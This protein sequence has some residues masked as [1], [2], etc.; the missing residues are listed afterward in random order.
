[1]IARV[2]ALCGAQYEWGVHVAAFSAPADSARSAGG[3]RQPAGRAGGAA[4]ARPT[5][6][7]PVRRTACDR[8]RQRCAVERTRPRV[9]H[10]A[11]D[12]T[13]HA[14][15]L[16]PGDQLRVQCR[17]RALEPGRPAG[18]ATGQRVESSSTSNFSVALGGITPPA[19][20]AP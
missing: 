6:G 2:C 17:R 12:R 7:A 20:R 3:D 16:V 14:G 13:A 8:H 4:A 9:E 15:G 10:A 11:A 1:V 19:P 5:A 18:D